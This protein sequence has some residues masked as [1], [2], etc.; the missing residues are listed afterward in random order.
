MNK[1]PFSGLAWTV[2]MPILAL[3]LLVGCNNRATVS[4]DPS[5]SDAGEQGF[6]MEGGGTRRRRS[7]ARGNDGTT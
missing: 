3:M 7:A 4:S 1:L 2:Y 5:S 6:S